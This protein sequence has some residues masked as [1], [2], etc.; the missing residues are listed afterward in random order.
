LLLSTPIAKPLQNRVR[1]KYLA[2][3]VVTVIAMSCVVGPARADSRRCPGVTL[4]PDNATVAEVQIIADR[5][6]RIADP[7]TSPSE[8]PL[9]CPLP[10]PAPGAGSQWRPEWSTAHWSPDWAVQRFQR[11]WILV[12]KPMSAQSA[13]RKPDWVV[14]V[15]G[16]RQWWLW[17][18]GG[19]LASV[20][21]GDGKKQLF[22][23][24]VA[25]A[26]GERVAALPSGA[27]VAIYNCALA[28]NPCEVPLSGFNPVPVGGVWDPVTPQLVV[29]SGSGAVD[30]ARTLR[31]RNLTDPDTAAFEP[32]RDAG[33]APW[34][35]CHVA[36]PTKDIASLTGTTPGIAGEAQM[37]QALLMLRRSDPCPITGRSPA[38][39]VNAWLGKA[40][41]KA[42][43]LPGTNSESWP[44]ERNGEL[45]VT[46]AGLLHVIFAYGT[47]H[48]NS[49]PPALSASVRKHLVDLLKPWGGTPRSGPYVE[50]DGTC[51]GVSILESE[52]HILL[53]ETDRYLID[54]LVFADD[55]NPIYDVGS[56]GT[57][58]WLLRF[59]RLQAR[60]DFYEYNSNPYGRYALKALW[61]LHDYA[62]DTPVRDAAKGILDWLFAKHAVSANLLRGSRPFRR[63]PESGFYNTA[64]WYGTSSEAISVDAALLAGGGL[65]YLSDPAN[66]ND[67][68]GPDTFKKLQDLPG[69]G[70]MDDGHLP[71]L[72]DV[73]DTS[74]RL[75]RPIA[76]WYQERF[77]ETGESQFYLQAIHHQETAAKPLADANQFRQWNAGAE[78]YSGNRNWTITAGGIDAQPADPGHPDGTWIA[79]AVVAAAG[80]V[81][82]AGIGFVVGG[83]AGAV[84]GGL[85][86]LVAGGLTASQVVANTQSDALWK[87]QA[88]LMR[89]TT[90]VP[91]ATGLDRSQTIRF[92]TPYV[93][94]K[95]SR[96]DAR[97]CVADG[98]MC[99]FDLRWPSNTFPDNACPNKTT[100]T[101]PASA[102]QLFD[103]H[104]KRGHFGCLLEPPR[105][106]REWMIWTFDKGQIAINTNDQPARA[107]YEFAWVETPQPKEP[108]LRNVHMDW[109]LQGD[110][111]DWFVV[112]GI[113]T[114]GGAE[115]SNALSSLEV[116]GD[117]NNTGKSD[118]GSVDFPLFPDNTTAAWDTQVE[119]CDPTY[120]VFR[121]GHKCNNDLLPN[122]H[123]NVAP[124]P[125][126]TFACAGHLVDDGSGSVGMEV[127]GKACGQ[128][129]GM[130]LY[131][132]NH[133][134][135]THDECPP[136]AQ[137]FGFVVASPADGWS[138][139]QFEAQVR[140]ITV[141]QD[142]N[143]V[144]SAPMDVLV[145]EGPSNG[146][147][148]SF[149]WRLPVPLDWAIV[150]ETGPSQGVVKSL[151][152][153]IEAWPLAASNVYDIISGRAAALIDAPNDQGCFT[154][155]GTAD[156]P[157]P[158][159]LVVD[160][161]P[162]GSPHVDDS[163]DSAKAR[164]ACK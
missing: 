69:L 148:V 99:G 118:K 88:S 4:A 34:L 35:P 9:G 132:Y 24:G 159:T 74:Y 47:V 38:A 33:I 62:P 97:M 60:R 15:R 66:L 49:P 22:H 8:G 131:V 57:R 54:H 70:S 141:R 7:N 158:R 80:L 122:L 126:E 92:G 106:Y 153:N 77:G 130:Y 82:G 105:P 18:H 61:L 161:R 12:R 1:L 145:P 59:L 11:G 149:R 31:M 121:T 6:Q 58:D 52:N 134:C 120:F 36:D 26:A 19:G 17:W 144:S 64:P 46:A 129:Y 56:N 71:E 138:Y 21:S 90:L 65:Q 63:L 41:L 42:G 108:G 136:G 111:H 30:F 151:G 95:D 102:Q 109:N 72:A 5:V 156:L 28:I 23:P 146:H 13:A 51:I 128:R 94:Q 152:T 142:F 37:S 154:V 78:L 10:T 104:Q 20:T 113:A 139:S 163:V 50:P 137:S 127:G 93:A 110:A 14:A 150:D 89:A 39:E 155:T 98:F 79:V 45:D 162:P 164:Q 135:A 75:P 81:G 160:L 32:R 115:S 84:A 117:Q 91:T 73:V 96:R 123:L 114:G 76:S 68:N 124:R 147:T 55:T 67:A 107:R 133:G 140:G 16:E 83:P 103:N 143:V 40:S 112:R 29:P 125:K 43:Q 116:I 86:G 3:G 44:C 2:A 157:E 25:A 85:I 87:T 53:Q 27:S 48:P 101:L 100:V 119:G